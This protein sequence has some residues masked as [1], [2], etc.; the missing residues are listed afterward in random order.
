ME[1]H[2]LS[3]LIDSRSR[4]I[5]EINLNDL[6]FP[7]LALFVSGGHTELCFDKNWMQY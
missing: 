6:K 3:T 7:M 1:G 2:I 4:E 5:Q